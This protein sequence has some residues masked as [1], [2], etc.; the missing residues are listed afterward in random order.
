MPENIV[1]GCLSRGLTKPCGQVE[2]AVR[3]CARFP[4]SRGDF[5]DDDVIPDVRKKKRKIPHSE[6][7]K[8]PENFIQPP[9]GS[10]QNS[11]GAGLQK[12]VKDERYRNHQCIH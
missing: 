3:A 11:T 6:M 7:L 9:L 2:T 4:K 1:N 12:G 10:R 8:H 5:G